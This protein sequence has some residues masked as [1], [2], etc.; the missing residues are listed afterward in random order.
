MKKLR[1]KF[2]LFENS[3]VK[4][5]ITSVTI[6]FSIVNRIVHS[7]RIDLVDG[8]RTYNCQYNLD[9]PINV[10]D[11]IAVTTENSQNNKTN[12]IYQPSSNPFLRN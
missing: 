11:R 5:A 6:T 4:G 12:P 9:D 10:Y 3:L 2:V 7:F 8:L 1:R